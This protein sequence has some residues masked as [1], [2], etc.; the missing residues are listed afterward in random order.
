MLK[1]GDLRNRVT[2]Q[3][4]GGDTN[5]WDEPRP[6]AWADVATI[7]ANIRHLSGSETI[8]A[9]AQTS[10]VKASIRIRW[11]TDVKAG[12][13]VLASGAVYAIEAVLPDLQRREFVDLVSRREG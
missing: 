1:A 4:K 13:R 9:D 5:E 3:K 7:W 11:R 8:K 2:I 6:Q 10:V 12:M